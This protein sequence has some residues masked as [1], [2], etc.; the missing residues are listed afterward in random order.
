MIVA[1]Q[2]TKSL[3][4][5]RRLSTQSL[6]EM[7]EGWSSGYSMILLP[8]FFT[9]SVAMAEEQQR[10]TTS[11]TTARSEVW[12]KYKGWSGTMIGVVTTTCLMCHLGGSAYDV[13]CSSMFEEVQRLT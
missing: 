1:Y 2:L 7:T 12:K 11:C 3:G 6:E 13:R 10:G 5:R 9:R 4:S 8:R